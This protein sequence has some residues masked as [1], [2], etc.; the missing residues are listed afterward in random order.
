MVWKKE[1]SIKNTVTS[2]I[3]SADRVNLKFTS[4]TSMP[5]YNGQPDG[6]IVTVP[7]KDDAKKLI[8]DYPK[9]FVIYTGKVLSAAPLKDDDA[10]SEDAL[11]V[12]EMVVDQPESNK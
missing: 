10:G 9:N 5:G 6:T 2:V 11:D 4:T 8:S 12:V 7:C 1:K 3:T